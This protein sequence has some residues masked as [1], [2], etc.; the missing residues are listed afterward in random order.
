M[1]PPFSYISVIIS[2]L[3]RAC[4]FIWTSILK[5]LLKQYKSP[6][7]HTKFKHATSN[8]VK[9]GSAIPNFEL[10]LDLIVFKLYTKF[11]LNIYNGPKE[12]ERK[13]FLICIF[14]SPRGITPSKSARQYPNSNLS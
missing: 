5:V 8:S 14:L 7:G 1:T 11:Q 10:E 6:T 9:K 4:P 12:N 13:P 2:P 3:K